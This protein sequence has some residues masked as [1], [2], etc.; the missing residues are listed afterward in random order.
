[1]AQ[2]STCKE[3]HFPQPFLNRTVWRYD[4][5]EPE[6]TEQRNVNQPMLASLLSSVVALAESAGDALAAEFFR[7]EGPRG[8]GGTRKSM[9]RSRSRF[10][11]SYWSSYRRAGGARRQGSW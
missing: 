6:A 4:C 11:L 5:S 7:P 2:S 3:K 10:E 8:Q 1:M 9:M